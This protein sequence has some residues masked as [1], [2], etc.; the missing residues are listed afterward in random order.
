ML[1]IIWGVH[2]LLIGTPEAMEK[3]EML[4]NYVKNHNRKLYFRLKRRTISGFTYLPGKVGSGITLAG[5]KAAQKIY[6]FN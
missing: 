6:Q 4:W 1:L 2:L 5:Y 3:R